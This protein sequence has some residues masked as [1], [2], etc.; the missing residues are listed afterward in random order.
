M[1]PAQLAAD[2]PST[3]PA[4]SE[5]PVLR[6]QVHAWPL[7]L[8]LLAIAAQLVGALDIL[9]LSG[10]SLAELLTGETLTP[11]GF[12]VRMLAVY[13]LVPFA[14]VQGLRWLTSASVVVESDRLV[15][16][17]RRDRF[18]VPFSSLERLRLW[19]LPFPGVGLTLG[20]KSGRAFRYGLQT[21]DPAPLLEALGQRDGLDTRAVDHPFIP[22]A[23]AR[24]E[25]VRRRWYHLAFKYVLFSLVPTVIL[26][27]LHQYIVYGGPFGEYQMFGPQRYLT[28]FAIYWSSMAAYLVLYSSFLRVLAEGVSLAWAWRAPAHVRGVRRWVEITCR[29]LIYAGVPSLIGA[30]ILLF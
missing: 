13:T 30:R 17:R 25:L 1:N 24:N 16:I 2:M 10:V 23:R 12:V 28:T 21:F 11:P 19:R 9:F 20:M 8:R 18:E 6:F 29:V 26:F 3:P 27:R 15:L 22:Y 7:P 5:A 14:L 4:S